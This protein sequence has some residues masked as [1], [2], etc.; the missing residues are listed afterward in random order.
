MRI[1]WLVN[2]HNQDDIKFEGLFNYIY[3]RAITCESD[4]YKTRENNFRDIDALVV[5]INLDWTGKSN[6]FDGIRLAQE[7]RL[8]DNVTIPIVFLSLSLSRE[9]ILCSDPSLDI[10]STFGLSNGFCFKNGNRIE[11]ALPVDIDNVTMESIDDYIKL[12]PK[13]DAVRRFDNKYFC[14]KK[15]QTR[16][17]KHDI[18]YNDIEQTKNKLISLFGNDLRI[19]N[20]TTREELCGLCD[21]LER[22]LRANEAKQSQENAIRVLLLDDKYDEDKGIKFFLEYSRKMLDIKCCKTVK[23]ALDTVENFNPN[24][25]LVDLRLQDNTKFP[26]INKQQGYD[27]LNIHKEKY[28]HIGIIILSRLPMAFLRDLSKSMSNFRAFYWK[29][30][31]EG[32][33]YCDILI[34]SITELAT[35][36]FKNDTPQKNEFEKLYNWWYGIDTSE[37]LSDARRSDSATSRTYEQFVDDESKEIIKSISEKGVFVALDKSRGVKLSNSHFKD[38]TI[39]S[40]WKKDATLSKLFIFRRVAIYLFYYL[41][42]NITTNEVIGKAFVEVKNYNKSSD[43]RYDTAIKRYTAEVV[44]RILANNWNTNKNSITNKFLFFRGK[45]GNRIYS[46]KDISLTKEEKEFF[47]RY[48]PHFFN[49]WNQKR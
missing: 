33:T 49:A 15:D 17:L 19:S 13:I 45:L 48:F 37:G 36:G 4:Y 12:L 32:T 42:E 20:A 21:T 29:K 46:Y 23:E 2:K 9:D 14:R 41:H 22:E 11:F 8:S 24:V 30:E 7:L 1:L 27:Y 47:A 31:L 44:N 5:Q 34:Q 35:T 43:S 3:H 18:V 26:I 40:G 38:L 28:P 10:I 6:I 25:V 39:Q 16:R